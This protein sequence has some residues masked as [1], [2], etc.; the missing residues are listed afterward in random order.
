MNIV[1]ITMMFGAGLPILFPLAS[2]S[3]L[4]MY[5]LEKYEI[6]YVFQ[7]PPSYDEKLNNA[8]LNNLDKAPIFLLSFGYW[9]LT[10][11]QLL[12]NQHLQPVERASDAFQSQHV[13]SD[14]CNLFKAYEA[15]PA[16]SLL[17]MLYFYIAYLVFAGP[18]IGLFR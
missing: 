11:L 14:Y 18:I 12:S 3:L 13:W 2:I 7:Q 6:Y 4:M 17:V 1:F 10:N 5:C 15:G 9:F 16:G 8:V